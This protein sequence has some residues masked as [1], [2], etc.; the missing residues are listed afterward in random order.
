MEEMMD[1]TIQNDDDDDLDEDEFYDPDEE[2]SGPT[3]EA[4]AGFY[5]AWD[6]FNGSLFG[7]KLPAC[8]I[9]MQRWAR[10]KGFFAGEQFGHRQQIPHQP[11]ITPIRS[12]MR[13]R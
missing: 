6:Y 8:L 7:N 2:F 10:S 3:R 9:T 4:Y 12:W 13:S 11:P 1:R 5:T